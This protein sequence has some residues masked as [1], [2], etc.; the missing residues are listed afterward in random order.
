MR[1]SRYPRT[2]WK[3]WKFPEN[4][5]AGVPITVSVLVSA[6]TIDNA[7]AH[8]GAFRPPRK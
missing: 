7:I 4:E 5:S 1:A 3:N 8:Q 6:D 2:T